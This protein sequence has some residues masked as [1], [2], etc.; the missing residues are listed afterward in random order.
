MEVPEMS[1]KKV[2]FKND[3]GTVLR[4]LLHLSNKPDSVYAIFAH[5]F[6]CSKDL[7]SVKTICNELARKGISVLRFDFTGLGESEGNFSDTNFSTNTLDIV[8]AA[9]YLENNY[10]PAELL[11]GH[12]LGGAAVI[13]IA[14]KISSSKAVVT[15]AAP[16]EPSHVLRHMKDKK[17]R[18]DSQ[19]EATVLI[20]GRPFKIKKQFLDDLE[21]SG[22]KNKIGNLRKALLVM[23]SPFDNTVGIDNATAIFVTAK[24]PKSFITLDNADHLISSRHDALYTGRVIAA[25]ADRYIER[26]PGNE[27]RQDD[28]TVKV[29]NDK[30]SYSTYI[31]TG[32]H[33][34]VSDEP[35]SSGGDDLG[36]D[37]YK[38]LLSSLG[39]C[40]CMTLRMYSNRKKWPLDTIKVSLS[41]EKIYAADCEDCETKEGKIDRITRRIELAGD[42]SSEQKE[43]LIEIADK[44]PVH[45][46]LNSE[47]SIRTELD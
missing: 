15:I 38:Y 18:I 23:H 29:I 46:T 11:I 1:V 33:L 44:C 22:M 3:S 45:R 21:E 17:D 43:R 26:D 13:Q 34:L 40:T 14:E 35:I 32:E 42:L 4:G 47:I 7:K 20:A 37:P 28:K 24:H 2:E 25:W 31:R 10:A 8:S 12:S 39:S 5:C 41:H 19:G 36:P 9:D 27:R 16:S 30:Y 6:T